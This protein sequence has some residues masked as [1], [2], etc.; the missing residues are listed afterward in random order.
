MIEIEN[1]ELTEEEFEAQKKIEK[2]R[3]EILNNAV[4]GRIDNIRDKVAYILNNFISARNSDIELAWLYWESF[5]KDKFNGS[6]ITKDELFKLTKIGSLTRVRAKI[7]NEYKLFQADDKVR[8][9]RGVLEE[10]KKQEAI[11]DK[12]SYPLYSVYIDETG[13][14]QQHLSVGSLWITE[15][16]TAFFAGMKL[17]DWKKENA[18]DYEFHFA[19]LKN[20]KLEHYK[21]FFLKFLVLNPTAGFKVITIKRS[22]LKNSNNAITDL[23]FHLLNNGIMH[24]DKSG[25]APLPRILQV[26]IDNEEEGSDL[27]K[28]ENLKERLTSQQINGLYIDHFEAIDSTRNFYLQAVD[29]FVSSINR[30]LNSELNSGN[31]KDELADYILDLLDFDLNNIDISNEHID[32]SKLFNLSYK[33]TEPNTL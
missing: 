28:V 10:E 14:T 1:V 24:E 33:K 7:Q 9:Y 31:P 30:K 21:E 5:E 8:K 17:K 15:A 29:L 12:P 18:I 2:K 22:G 25:R 32:K 23:T 13:K 19:E 26:Y 4:S 6:S 20:H 11:E 27:L 3:Q 16:R